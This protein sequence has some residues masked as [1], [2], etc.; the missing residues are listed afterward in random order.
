MDDMELEDDLPDAVEYSPASHLV[1]LAE[2]M[3][4]VCDAL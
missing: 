3:E 4:P 2:L 1:Q